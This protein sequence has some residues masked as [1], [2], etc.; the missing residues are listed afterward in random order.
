MRK[1]KLRDMYAVRDGHLKASFIVAISE[2]D[3]NVNFLALPQNEALHVPKKDVT[4]G[5]KKNILDFVKRIPKNHFKVCESQYNISCRLEHQRTPL[6]VVEE[7]DET[8]D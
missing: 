3:D 2:D 4:F 5:L 6:K 7:E 8:T 1:L